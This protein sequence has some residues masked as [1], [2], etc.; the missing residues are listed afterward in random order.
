MK[1]LLFSI[2]VLLSYAAS[3]QE[4]IHDQQM[5]IENRRYL[6]NAIGA[7]SGQESK[8]AQPLILLSGDK[9]KQERLIL[10]S[11][12]GI[13]LAGA[14]YCTVKAFTSDMGGSDEWIVPG[15]FMLMM[16]FGCIANAAE[17]PT[18]A[19]HKLSLKD[20]PPLKEVLPAALCF[21]VAGYFDGVRDKRLFHTGGPVGFTN[22]RYPL[23]VIGATL[24]FGEWKV[25]PIAVKFGANFVAHTVGKNLGYEL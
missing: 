13:F 19:Y 11:A 6:C 16:S 25:G 23:I 12:G 17:V 1:P 14:T 18:Q 3:G 15:C 5:C 7:A 22:V 8:I 24:S 21:G 9:V 20:L 2:S 10:T 4:T